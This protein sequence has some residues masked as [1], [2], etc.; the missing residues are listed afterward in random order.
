MLVAHPDTKAV[1]LFASED[2]RMVL[3]EPGPDG[4]EV[5]TLGARLATVVGPA[6]RITW[7]G[8]SAEI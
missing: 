2:D 1:E 8:G 5:T 3:V 6:L 4:V 7:D